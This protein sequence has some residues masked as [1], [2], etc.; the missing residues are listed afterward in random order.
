MTRDCDRFQELMLDL[1]YEEIDPDLADQLREHA[2]ACDGCREELA[3][4]LLTRKLAA[5]LPDPEPPIERDAAILEIAADAAAR[6]SELDRRESAPAHAGALNGVE[7]PIPLMER[8]RALLLKPALVTAGVACVV[9]AIAIFVNQNGFDADEQQAAS[10]P[11][12]P[13]HGPAVAVASLE[14]TPPT[15]DREPLARSRPEATRSL[16]DLPAVA[17]QAPAPPSSL[18]TGGK[19]KGADRRGLGTAA[20]P[21]SNSA[22]QLAPAQPA[23]AAKAEAAKEAYPI[24]DD[25]DALA[26]P[27]LA[28]PALAEEESGAAKSGFAPAPPMAPAPQMAPEPVAG[29]DARFFKTGMQA[30]DRGD[31]A[32][33]TTSLRR[34]VD[35]PNDAPA[36]IPT[37]LHHVAR[38]EKRTGRCGKA[39]VSYEELLQRFPSYG[40]RP[41]AMWEAAGCH[42]RLGHVDRAW[43]LL[44]DLAE[45]PGWRERALAEQENLKQIKSQK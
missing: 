11:G 6:F 3:S 23:A 45:I 40:G 7:R 5:Q 22:A 44:D 13:F 10:E 39:L 15:P 17:Q 8:L 14:E 4:I 2:S 36:L 20:A 31:C 27:A 1:A 16:G 34:V 21:P 25:L 33:A 19:L 38:C 35:P 26:G 32:T 28:G 12:A 9:L 30:Y 41:E 42:R 43:A 29:D 24:A 18:G 37:A